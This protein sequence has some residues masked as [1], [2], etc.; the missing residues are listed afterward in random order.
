MGKCRV[1]LM[2]MLLA[3]AGCGDDGGDGT[4]PAGAGAAGMTAGAGAAGMTAGSGPT[5]GMSTAGTSGG[6][7]GMGGGGAGMGGAGTPTCAGAM[8]GAGPALHMAA[9]QAITQTMGPQASCAG[10]T[11]CH[12]GNNAQAGLS[13]A[14]PTNLNMLLVGKMSC[15]LPTMPLVASGG[16]DAALNNSWLWLKLIAPVDASQ[17][18]VAMPAWGTPGNCGQSTVGTFGLRMPFGQT[19][20][21]AQRDPVRD[22]ICA[23]APGP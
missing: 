19:L 8:T 16:G 21:M 6:G 15:E 3:V 17:N 4:I 9:V 11:A 10:S 18:V 1:R 22:W 23:G 12:A 13:L 2:M 7:A 14:G 20:A 5:A